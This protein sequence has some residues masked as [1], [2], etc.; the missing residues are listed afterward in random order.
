[1]ELKPIRKYDIL[2]YPTRAVLDDH[3]ELLM[4]APARWQSSPAI[5]AFLTAG[6]LL[7]AAGYSRSQDNEPVIMGTVASPSLDPTL[8]KVY[9]DEDEARKIIVEEAKRFGVDLKPT[10]Q[11]LELTVLHRDYQTNIDQK[12]P[13]VNG[14]K[15]K[16]PKTVTLKIQLDGQDEKRKIFFEYISK[17]DMDQWFSESPEWN[18]ATY[19]KD[20]KDIAIKLK[21]AVIKKKPKTN[22]AMFYDP[23]T[24]ST[25]ESKE[26]LKQQVKIYID[27]LKAQGII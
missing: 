13:R 1:M 26:K 18:A 4:I 8:Q 16:A 15:N 11:V 6:L 9:L 19:R 17:Q 10:E 20:T 2:R 3:P 12:S 25:V 23:V 14:N 27:W 5:T 21:D 7:F 24:Y 22:C